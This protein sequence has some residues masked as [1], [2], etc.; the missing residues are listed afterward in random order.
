MALFKPRTFLYDS[1]INKFCQWQKRFKAYYNQSNVEDQD[2]DLHRAFVNTYIDD[3]LADIIERETA[4]KE[5]MVYDSRYQSLFMKI[6]EKYF[7]NLHP[8]HI[9]LN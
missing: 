3:N 1:T 5:A 7:S 6:L 2:P 9:R 8:I 4:G